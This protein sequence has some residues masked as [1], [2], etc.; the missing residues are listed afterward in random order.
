MSIDEKELVLMGKAIDV[1]GDGKFDKDEIVRKFTREERKAFFAKKRASF[2]QIIKEKEEKLKQ[3]ME[4]K[5]KKKEESR[6]S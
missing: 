5:K 6:K 2:D 1:N 4:D 3:K